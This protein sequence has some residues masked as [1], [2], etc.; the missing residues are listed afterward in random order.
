[1]LRK[2]FLATAFIMIV[3]SISFTVRHFSRGNLTIDNNENTNTAV[4]LHFFGFKTGRTQFEIFEKLTRNF[5]KENPGIFIDYEGIANSENYL[6]ILYKRIESQQTDDLFML[7]PFA[8]SVVKAKGYINTEIY[9][10]K[11]EPFLQQYNELIQPLLN[12]DGHVIA[13]PME[14][15]A[16]G[17]FVNMDILSQYG[18]HIPRTLQELIECCAK[19][20]EAGITPLALSVNSLGYTSG[21]IFATARALSV[22]KP[23]AADFAALR[24][25]KASLGEFFKPGLELVAE[26]TKQHFWNPQKENDQDGWSS[27]METF[28]TQQ[29]AFMVGGTWQINRIKL[30]SKKFSFAFVPLPFGD[31]NNVVSIRPSS[32]VCI[33]KKGQHKDIALKFLKYLSKKENISD[34]TQSQMALSPLKDITDSDIILYDIHKAV[35]EGRVVTDSDSRFG[36]NLVN[37]FSAITTDLALQKKTV[38][39]EVAHLNSL[40]NC[41]DGYMK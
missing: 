12:V 20:K 8:F 40:L 16:I 11:D 24:C 17:M 13:L 9:D 34:F 14:M 10:L 38:E 30:V 26:F 1:M 29:S 22:R 36:F 5:E 25:G 35:A 28:A 6:E 3:A 2:I 18:L 7:N 23:T 33:N 39:E 21:H 32:P 27:D 4:R 37:E 15:G 19:L 41:D 31:E